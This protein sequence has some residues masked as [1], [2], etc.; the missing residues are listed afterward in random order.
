[1]KFKIEYE[2]DIPESEITDIDPIE[3]R[4]FVNSYV[5]EIPTIM[6]SKFYRY[7]MAD[8]N[9]SNLTITEIV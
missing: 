3:L 8:F 6:G 7:D 2:I 9:P 1:M 5:E 4:S